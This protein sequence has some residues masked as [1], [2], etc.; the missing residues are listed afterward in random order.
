VKMAEFLV[1]RLGAEEN[2]HSSWIAVDNAGTRRTPPVIGPLH[3]AVKDIGDR[4]VI[5]LVPAGETST[6]TCDLPAKG[7]RLLAAL[8]FALEEQVADEIENLHFAPGV[9]RSSGE[10]SVVVVAH[11]K[12]SGWLDRLREA[13]IKPARVIA[14]DHGLAF[15]PNTLSMLVAE[16]QIVFN[17]GADLQFVMQGV[18]P[19]DALIA[20]GILGEAGLSE[21]AE[22]APR[23]LLV[24]CEPTDEQRFG[25]D[26]N[27]LR[28]HLDS[29][30]INLLPDGVLPKLAVTVASGVG[31]NL[32]QGRYGE[33]TDMSAIFRPW[34]Y[35]AM[36]LL[37]F[38]VLGIAGK[39]IDYVRLSSEEVALKEQFTA[40]YRKIRPDDTRE[41]MDPLGT[42]TSIRRSL[43]A[44]GS[45][46]AVFLP[47]LQQLAL[48][49]Q[50][51]KG[52]E[53]VAISYR[54]G[55]IDVRLTAPDVATLD[56]I[57]KSVSQSS[58]F[59]ASIQSTDRV[60]DQVNSRIQIREVGS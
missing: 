23:H 48:A 8:P 21:Q 33:R 26:W 1:I 14:E 17:D 28:Q 43:G 22:D 25:N 46:P 37:A 2:N 44:G 12:M 27:A 10:L 24:Y 53:I 4:Q 39:A 55:V 35:A 54:A 15:V 34:R 29:V 19:T 31:V 13:G 32:L 49:M 30:D 47:S 18:S 3:E 40:E 42:V 38:G 57:E 58:R 59:T 60:G 6:L 52:A 41:V 50:E 16:D 51:N 5:V 56:K 20:A 36:L 7:A 45:A 9:R 11:D